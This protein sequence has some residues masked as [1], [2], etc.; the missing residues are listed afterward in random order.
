M[1]VSKHFA[2]LLSRNTRFRLTGF[3]HVDCKT[4][5]SGSQN[6]LDV[7]HVHCPFMRRLCRCQVAKSGFGAQKTVSLW[8]WGNIKTQR[9]KAKSGFVIT[10]ITIM[11]PKFPSRLRGK[12]LR[13]QK[14]VKLGEFSRIVTFSKMRYHRFL[15]DVIDFSILSLSPMNLT[16]QSVKDSFID[17]FWR[18]NFL[19]MSLMIFRSN[20]SCP[21]L[22]I[23]ILNA[24]LPSSSCF[25][26][27]TTAP[28]SFC[29]FVV[30]RHVQYLPS[31]R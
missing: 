27:A 29:S 11:S 31:T 21:C 23:N 17:M 28:I 26:A 7:R 15:D 13:R 3:Y 14:R 20:L 6:F 25:S 18:D 12:D 4:S 30:R 9:Q 22:N 16:I 8:Q 5:K 2:E 1:I 24:T 19:L 10:E